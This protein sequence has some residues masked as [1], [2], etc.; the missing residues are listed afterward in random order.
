M[1][2]SGK[3]YSLDS[4]MDLVQSVAASKDQDDDSKENHLPPMRESSMESANNFDGS[5]NLQ[6]LD[7][8]ATYFRILHSRS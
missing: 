2:M 3:H 5:Y 4:R 1:L 6:T 8:G 7:T